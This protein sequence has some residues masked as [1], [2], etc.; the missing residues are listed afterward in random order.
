MKYAAAWILLVCSTPAV[1]CPPPADHG[2]HEPLSAEDI[3]RQR[4]SYMPNIVYAVVER[5]IAREG[6]SGFPR[7]P[8]VVRILHVYKGN[9]RPRQR[10]RMYGVS[11]HTDCGNLEY[12]REDA[13]RGAYGVLLLSELSNEGSQPFVRFESPAVVEDMIRLGLIESARANNPAMAPPEQ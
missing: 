3:L 12:S 4:V 1:A 8:G 11:Q 2:S 5:T 9:L 13:R 7:G 10:I 6:A